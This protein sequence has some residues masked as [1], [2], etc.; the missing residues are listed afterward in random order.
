LEELERYLKG[1]LLTD[2][3]ASAEA[4]ARGPASRLARLYSL[5]KDAGKLPE[6]SVS[7]QMA[8]V[9][10]WIFSV[11]QASLTVGAP[12]AP[13][14]YEELAMAFWDVDLL[15]NKKTI[16]SYWDYSPFEAL[17]RAPPLTEVEDT[18]PPL[19]A[20]PAATATATEEEEDYS[21][22]PPLV[23]I[24][25]SFRASEDD[26]S[27]MPG[28]ISLEELRQQPPPAVA[29]E[30]LRQEASEELRQEASEEQEEQE[31]YVAYS[32]TPQLPQSLI[33]TVGGSVEALFNFAL[34]PV[35]VPV[36]GIA[37]ALAILPTLLMSKC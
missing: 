37:L 6:G 30:E 9:A 25:S 21:D 17:R 35:T 28:L 12:S 11:I 10:K 3:S 26:Y 16:G 19:P 15:P 1:P 32:R 29:S 13:T 34:R 8:Y 36:W 14:E 4:G 2:A 24:D 22:M 23:P 33:D 20:S 18:V 27:D 7:E 5:L 31:E